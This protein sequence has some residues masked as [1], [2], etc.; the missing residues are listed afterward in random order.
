MKRKHLSFIAMAIISTIL[1]VNCVKQPEPYKGEPFDKSEPKEIEFVLV[2]GG[3]FTMGNAEAEYSVVLDSFYISKHEITQAQWIKVMGDEKHDDWNNTFGWGNNF[4]AYRV[5]F[6]DIQEFISKLNAEQDGYFYSLP[7]EA[8]WEIAARG[9]SQSNGYMYAGSDI[10]KDVAWY[11]DNSEINYHP[12]NTDFKARLASHI[13]GQKAANELGLF[14]MSGNLSE[15]C[16]DFVG[17]KYEAGNTYYNPRGAESGTAHIVRG[18][19]FTSDTTGCLVTTRTAKISPTERSVYTGFRLVRKN[20]VPAES[21]TLN[22][23]K[24][25]LFS[26]EKQKLSA[27]ILPL[28]TSV[29]DVTWSSSKTGVARVDEFGLVTA[30]S[31]NKITFTPDTAM[32]YATT[33]YRDVEVKDS[34]MVIVGVIDVEDVV[35][36]KTVLELYVG[37]EAQLTATVL[38]ENADFKNVQWTNSN[39]NMIMLDNNGKIK[40]YQQGTGGETAII[41]VANYNGSITATCEITV[42]PYVAVIGVEISKTSIDVSVGGTYQLSANVLPAN[43]SNQNLIWSSDNA[44]IAGVG[45]SG[46][47]TGVAAGTTKITVKTQDGNF[48]KTCNVKVQ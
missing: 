12:E 6:K 36:N 21:L 32:I 34:C 15:I 30:V 2:E 16:N 17:A 42:V 46:L 11:K 29:Q 14:D 41:T 45:N 33:K 40:A 25:N 19:N 4:P 7:T 26:G 27:N 43:A 35:L 18:G 3:T 39:P 20:Y 44:A 10:I 37:Q 31:P 13:I 9:G 5:S 47:V 23:H 38:P 24:I 48:Q 28:N 8:E 1:F 22:E